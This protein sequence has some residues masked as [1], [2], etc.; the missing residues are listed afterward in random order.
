ML[1]IRVADNTKFLSM[2]LDLTLEAAYCL[3]VKPTGEQDS[4]TSS[5]INTLVQSAR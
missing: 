2:D 3:G 5:N 4:P 1:Y